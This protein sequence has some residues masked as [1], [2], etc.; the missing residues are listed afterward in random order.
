M[1]QARRPGLTVALGLSLALAGCV[2]PGGPLEAAP[3]HHRTHRF[4]SD[5]LPA[6]SSAPA[7]L[8]DRLRLALHDDDDQAAAALSEAEARAS[9]AALADAD[10]VWWLGHATVLVQIGGHRVLVDPVLA[11]VISPL[12]PLGPRRLAPSPWSVEGLPPLSA[13]LVTHDHYDHLEPATLAAI[14]AREPVPC[15]VPLRVAPLLERPCA[16]TE[17]LDWGG[18]WVR[19]GLTVTLLPARHES[20]RGLLDRNE[21]LWGS[22]L[23]EAGGRRVYI[24]GDTGYGDHFRAIGLAHGP[25]T[26]AILSLGG[27]LPRFSNST[28]HTDPQQTARAAADLR[29]ERLLLVHWGTYT[30]GTENPRAAIEEVRAAMGVAPVPLVIT[31][32]GEAVRF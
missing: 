8:A 16:E 20:G 28:V 21:T 25:I 10:G 11:R 6:G 13:A 31:R 15:L 1:G 24:G 19:D 30:M 17:E 9:F 3:E 18:R 4:R 14:S 22:Y 32:I 2:A 7:F 29:A 27:Y 5:W 12:P 23:I 26:L